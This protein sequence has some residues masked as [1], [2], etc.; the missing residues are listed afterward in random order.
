MCGQSVDWQ[1]GE[2]SGHRFEYILWM[3]WFIF[4]FD[5]DSDF[6]FLDVETKWIY[7]IRFSVQLFWFGSDRIGGSGVNIP[8][9]YIKWGEL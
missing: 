2:L 6:G 4:G 3:V 7:V 8:N 1:N 5:S 9:E